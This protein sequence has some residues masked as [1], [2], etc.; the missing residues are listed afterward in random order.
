M[1]KI[2]KKYINTKRLFNKIDG[3]NL[4]ISGP[5]GTKTLQ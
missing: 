1:S 4:T 2:G 5:K 3:S